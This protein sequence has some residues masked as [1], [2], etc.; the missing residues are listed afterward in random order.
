M[1]SI[2]SSYGDAVEAEQKKRDEIRTVVKDI[3]LLVRKLQST[4]DQAHAGISFDEVV[5][6]TEQHYPRLRELFGAL[7]GII[8]T[9]EYYRYNDHWRNSL[10]QI[11]F[12]VAMVGWMQHDQ[13]VTP[14]QVQDILQL[15]S[16]LRV[17]LEDYLLG[18][19]SLPNELSRLCVNSVTAG[20]V[21]LPAR[22]SRFVQE[23]F[24]GFRL[25]N[26]KNDALRRRFDSIKYDVKKIEEV[27]YDITLRG[28]AKQQS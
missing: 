7:A 10:Q 28:L 2:F 11:V 20:H 8:P 4:L 25:L 12:V 6:Q 5:K 18:L 13:L 3:D 24:A 16:P 23:L 9:E 14:E 22:I 26:L 15:K 21:G 19:C 17:D 27:M 1:Q